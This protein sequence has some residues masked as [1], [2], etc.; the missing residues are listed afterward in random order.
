MQRCLDGMEGHTLVRSTQCTK[1]K[2]RCTCSPIS[3]GV[4]HVRSPGAQTYELPT[5]TGTPIHAPIPIKHTTPAAS[6][7]ITGPAGGGVGVRLPGLMIW[8][9]SM[10]CACSTCRKHCRSDVRTCS[11]VTPTC[12]MQQRAGAR[13]LAHFCLAPTC[14]DYESTCPHAQHADRAWPG[15]EREPQVGNCCCPIQEVCNPLKGS[16]AYSLY[17]EALKKKSQPGCQGQRQ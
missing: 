3:H 10:T 1:Q 2:P 4:V 6:C 14:L 15:R 7:G 17:D 5:C 16:V 11:R 13:S 8:T 12:C 9:L